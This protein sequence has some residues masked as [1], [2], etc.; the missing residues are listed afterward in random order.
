M[1]DNFKFL[2][3]HNVDSLIDKVLS[4]SDEDWDVYTFRQD[5]YEV[6]NQTRTVPILI[7]ENYTGQMGRK[8]SFYGMFE[9]EVK[10]LNE[11]LRSES[12]DGEIIRLEIVKLPPNSSIRLHKD[13]TSSLLFHNRIHIPLQTHPS[14]LFQVGDEIMH[15]RVGEIWEIDNGNKLHGVFNESDVER[16]HVIVDWRNKP[17][18]LF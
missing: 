5:V 18:T 16:I 10:N 7:D 6:H 15:M 13:N 1:S 3:N 2:G 8:T 14:C 12:M 4:L 11:S 9:D 17:I